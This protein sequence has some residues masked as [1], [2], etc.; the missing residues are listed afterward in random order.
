[1]LFLLG[2]SNW[3]GRDSWLHHRIQG[4]ISGA[5]RSTMLLTLLSAGTAN[6]QRY[7]LIGAAMAE[8]RYAE[9]KNMSDSHA[10][11]ARRLGGGTVLVD[12]RKPAV[13]LAVRDA[14]APNHTGL[15]DRLKA[16]IETLSGMSMD[17]V[18]V[19][20]NSDK[21]KQL[22]AHAYAQGS[23]IHLG[24]GQEKHLP[25]E[26]WHVV[27]QQQ[28]RVKPTMQFSHNVNDDKNLENEAD[29][30]GRKALQ[31]VTVATDFKGAK[32]H[33]YK[34]SPIQLKWIEERDEFKWDRL[35]DGVQWFGARGGAMYYRIVDEGK[36]K[37][38]SK[39]TY[40]AMENKPESHEFWLHHSVAGF[41]MLGGLDNSVAVG[42]QLDEDIVDTKDLQLVQTGSQFKD[43]FSYGGKLL[44]VFKNG[45]S[46]GVLSEVAALHKIKNSGLATPNPEVIEVTH[47]GIKTMGIL[48]D[49]VDG[50]FVDVAKVGNADLVW[51]ALNEA[52]A[53]KAVDTREAVLW[54]LI[55][56][57]K[58]PTKPKEAVLAA[59]IQDLKLIFE[60]RH[61]LVINDLQ[62]IVRPTGHAVIIDPQWAGDGA[63]LISSAEGKFIVD[64]YRKLEYVLTRLEGKGGKP[65]S[66]ATGSSFHP[67]GGSGS[68]MGKFE[69]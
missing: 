64:T 33:S 1:M 43:M 14:P 19:H 11:D 46:S 7:T 27:Q 25:H 13:Q 12:N 53:G 6:Y 45:D 37:L 44:S 18:K 40:Q 56:V 10:Q 9:R 35:I 16:G 20:Y 28:G 49:K 62:I 47:K 54:K 15:P 30:M 52:A 8:Y 4:G 42:G 60:S 66:S 57:M 22:H 39:A 51:I 34:N 36:I 5:L 38:G 17:H 26:A 65:A 63:T 2:V 69:T 58:N 59:L 32:N 61:R 31:A 55:P 3:P 50:I 23:D 21:P 48:M 29:V 24:A 68:G 41:D 67:S